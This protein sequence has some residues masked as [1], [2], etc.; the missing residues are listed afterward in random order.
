MPVVGL[1]CYTASLSLI[2]SQNFACQVRRNADTIKI[3]V[4]IQSMTAQGKKIRVCKNTLCIIKQMKYCEEFLINAFKKRL[5]RK[6]LCLVQK[7]NCFSS[8][9]AVCF[10]FVCF[11]HFLVVRGSGQR[12]QPNKLDI[13]PSGLLIER[14]IR[15]LILSRLMLSDTV[16]RALLPSL[17]ALSQLSENNLQG[18]WGKNK[19]KTLINKQSTY[20]GLKIKPG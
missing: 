10:C 1:I 12:S 19:E 11:C 4:L 2:L 15:Y 14:I 9:P 7:S 3:R 13:H 8:R 20:Q 5:R 17:L 6:T 18:E 16:F